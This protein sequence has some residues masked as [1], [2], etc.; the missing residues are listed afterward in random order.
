MLQ[1]KTAIDL[2]LCLSLSPSV[3][4]AAV[5]C[6]YHCQITVALATLPKAVLST[7]EI[8]AVHTYSK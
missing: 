1:P 5:G 6:D 7:V 2:K 3:I 4:G 8:F